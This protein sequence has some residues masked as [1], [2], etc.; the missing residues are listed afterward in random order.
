MG[1]DARRA[2]GNNR[3]MQGSTLCKFA[4]VSSSN[5]NVSFLQ[6]LDADGYLKCGSAH[7]LLGLDGERTLRLR[8]ELLKQNASVW[9]EVKLET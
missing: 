5:L 6:C 9:D 4:C 8:R 7:F 1:A 3:D 2:F